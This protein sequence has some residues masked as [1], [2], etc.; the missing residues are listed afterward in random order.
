MRR[1]CKRP[2]CRKAVI[3]QKSKTYCSRKCAHADWG[4]RFKAKH[5]ISYTAAA[6]AYTAEK[7]SSERDEEMSRIEALIESRR[8]TMPQEKHLTNAGC[9]NNRPYDAMP[10]TRFVSFS[11]RWRGQFIF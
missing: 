6:S 9:M 1:K 2:G 7:R 3:G 11:K 4:Q 8:A 10:Q 5:G